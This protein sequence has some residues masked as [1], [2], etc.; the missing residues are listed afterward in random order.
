MSKRKESNSVLIIDQLM[1]D[2]SAWLVV[3]K[4]VIRIN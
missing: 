3:Y 2:I 4:I 1:N